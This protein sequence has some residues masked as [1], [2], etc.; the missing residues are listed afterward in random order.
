MKLLFLG[1]GT[2]HGVPVIGC[3]CAVCAS[4]DPRNRRTRV[5]ALVREGESALLI[6]TPP[7]FREQMLR[8]R[9]RRVDAVLFTHA[10]ADHI[11]GL[12]DVRILCNMQRAPMPVY[13]SPETLAQLRQKFD[14]VFDSRDFTRG[15][16][17]PRLTA[18]PLTGPAQ[19]AGVE[20]VPTPIRHG[21]ATIL[22][23]RFGGLAYLTDCSGVPEETLALLR[24]LDTVVVGAIR[25]ER[26]P[27][28]FSVGEALELI[29]R[30]KPRR[31]FITHISHRL[32]HAST[33]ANLPGH[34][35]LAYDGLEIE[36]PAAASAV[37]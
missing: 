6:D 22:G 32:E 15:W 10:H 20:V 34:V 29:E 18:H 3:D 7:D 11:F 30:L 24:G 1:S 36:F 4:A 28:H 37:S 5:S 31:A 23:Y 12:D 9:V 35:R 21:C 16:D 33:E 17:V 14:Y 27:T 26:H 19:I 8:H 25:H 13:G 2:S